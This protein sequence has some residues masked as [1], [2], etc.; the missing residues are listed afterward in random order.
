MK[1]NKSAFLIDTPLQL[2]NAVTFILSHEKSGQIDL[3]IVNQFKNCKLYVN[4]LKN[5][6]IFNNIFILEKEKKG[7]FKHIYTILGLLAPKLYCKILLNLDIEAMDYQEIYLG[8]PT[9]MFDFVIGSSKLS[10][11]YGIEDGIG[12]Y[13]G[14]IFH[15]YL[16]NKYILARQICGRDYEIE[17]LFLRIPDNYIG[18]YN[19][20]IYSLKGSKSYNKLDIYDVFAYKKSNLYESKIIYLNQPI[21]DFAVDH[22]NYEK[23]IVS[24][25]YSYDKEKILVRLHPREE[26][27]DIYSTFQVDTENNM[28][29]ILCSDAIDG[30]T[31]IIG[32]FSTAQFV[33]KY[34]YNIE[35]IIVFTYRLYR[36]LDHST[37][38]R[39]EKQAS[40]LKKLYTNKNRVKIISSIK[41][42][43][44]II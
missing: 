40:Q 26:N 3:Y 38:L 8:A 19:G 12:S 31:C 1:I 34:F 10:H 16:S 39:Y 22:I 2:L 36:D 35:P 29:E 6:K 15:D 28:W 9:K 41:E 4:R 43:D 32:M 44:Y 13:S 14:D 17:R 20:I 24:K 21:K 27:Y 37:L 25:L 5:K 23:Q 42:L 30:N 7:M 18:L 33:P 11:V